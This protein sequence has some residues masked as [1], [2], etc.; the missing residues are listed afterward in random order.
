MTMTDDER[1]IYN[2]KAAQHLIPLAPD[3]FP[4]A[5]D[6]SGLELGVLGIK[7]LKVDT[8]LARRDEL[9]GEEI[10]LRNLCDATATWLTAAENGNRDP[11]IAEARFKA[12]AEADDYGKLQ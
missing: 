4:A 9:S 2:F 10:K 5:H 12:L 1:A 8:I 11:V 6:L 3:G 7:L